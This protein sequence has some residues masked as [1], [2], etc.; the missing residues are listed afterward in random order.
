[1]LGSDDPAMFH[2]TLEREYDLAAGEF[3]FTNEELCGIV[4]NGFRYAFRP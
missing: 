4:E 2:T 1:V 3:G